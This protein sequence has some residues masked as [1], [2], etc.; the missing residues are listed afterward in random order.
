M[1]SPVCPAS[2]WVSVTARSWLALLISEHQSLQTPFLSPVF[3]RNLWPVRKT[4]VVRSDTYIGKA[5]LSC[6]IIPLF[7]C[8][9]LHFTS[10]R[11]LLSLCIHLHKF[12]YA[13]DLIRIFW[14]GVC[15]RR[16]SRTVLVVWKLLAIPSRSQCRF[17]PLL[18]DQALLN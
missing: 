8:F 11:C 10:A 9:T 6:N 16:T 14:G 13:F 2:S 4:S 12:S 1:T 17:H 5:T 3:S 7:P 18:Y 15:F